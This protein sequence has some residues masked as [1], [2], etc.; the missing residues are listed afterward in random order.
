MKSSSSKVVTGAGYKSTTAPSSKMSS[1]PYYG[2][3]GPKVSASS[4]STKTNGRS[5]KSR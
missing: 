4:G 2:G 5:P 1:P 3:K